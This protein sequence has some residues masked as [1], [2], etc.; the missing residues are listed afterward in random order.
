MSPLAPAKR[1]LL[2][3]SH[4]TTLSGAPLALYYLARW[5]G[6]HG[7]KP[8]VAAPEPGPISDLLTAA[9][10]ETILDPTFLTDKK[11]EKLEAVCADFDIVVANTLASWPAVRAARS[12]GCC[13]IWYLHETRVAIELMQRIP[14][15]QPTLQLA[16]LLITPTRQTAC[17]YT[18][19]TR[20][21]IEVVPYGI[22][23][24]AISPNAALA[25]RKGG[26]ETVSGGRCSVIA[27]S[28][29]RPPR[30]VALPSRFDRYTA[31]DGEPLKF[32]CLGSYEPR[33][34]QDIL[35]EAIERLDREVQRRS[36]FHFAGRVLEG[37]FFAA[38]QTRAARLEN[39]QLRPAV[40]HAASLQLLADSDVLICSSRD[41]T[42]PISIIE[43]MSFGKNIISADVGG[44]AEW[45]RDGLNGWLVA[46]EN[47]AA[48]AQTIATCASDSRLREICATSARQTFRKHFMIDQFGSGFAAAIENAVRRH[49]AT[50]KQEPH[51]YRQWVRDY[52]TPGPGDRIELRRRLRALHRWPR[53]SILVPVYNADLK[54]LATAIDSVRA[55]VYQNWELCLAD[56]ASTD[57]KVRP[58]LE[59]AA[60]SDPRIK[61]T[62]RATNGHISAASNS[63]LTLATGDWCVLLDQDDAFAEDA[64]GRVA[65]EIAAHPETRVIYSDEDKIDVAGARSNPFFKTDWNPELFLGQNFIN[66]L[67]AYE[68]ALLREIGG[69]REGYEGSQDYDLAARCFDRIRP[70]QVRHIPRILYH[71]RSVPGSLAGMPNAKPYAREAARRALRDHLSRR[72][73][74][75]RVEPCPENNESHRVLYA[76]TDP[77]PLVTIIIPTRDRLFLLRR[78]VESLRSLTNYPAFEI[79]LVDNDSAEIETLEYFRQLEAEGAATVVRV[80]GPFNFSR[81]NN[82]AAH[83]ARGE[84]LALLNSDIEVT[85]SGWLTEMASHAARPEVGAVGARLW[86]RDGTLQH[87]AV[88]LGLGGVAGH[89]HHRVPHG[90]PGYFNRAF[91]QQNC[92]AVTAACLL[93]R[94][95]IFQQLGGFNEEDFGIN[96][97]D[98]DYCLRLRAHG[99][100]VIWTPYANLMHDESGSRGHHED[101]KEKAQFFREATCMQ[102]RYGETLLH[103]PFYNPNLSLVLHS[104][105]LAFPPRDGGLA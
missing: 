73:I 78:C 35:L 23:D 21:K 17:S 98:V 103:D 77:A 25:R 81:L 92:S 13:A 20:T 63:A 89:A 76:L 69:F 36:S 11:R 83:H 100:Q 49:H 9:G 5:L 97:N 85:E 42:M 53:F 41:E 67:G 14:E 68:T 54:F 64:L 94:K 82:V 8:V 70:T 16:D 66:H 65:L 18:G 95:K 55:Q 43:A 75:G 104:Y 51:D 105:E 91:L 37:A 90:H 79:L 6:E 56:D 4:E 22:P 48:L 38:L 72:G 34:G 61:L 84:I 39:V 29:T 86:Y 44:I 30:R 57:P 27:V 10:I 33:K 50:S 47:P 32:L 1:R 7:E 15:I 31:P 19:V 80:P 12:A 88:V 45:L 101:P 59:Q 28:E 52:D 24:L 87:G 71:W 62:L 46:P 93:T 3:F 102:E 58:F 2:L 40:D 74:S 99:L 60:A 96:F 26:N